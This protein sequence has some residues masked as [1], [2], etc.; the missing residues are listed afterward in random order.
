MGDLGKGDEFTRVFLFL[1]TGLCPTMLPSWERVPKY[2]GQWSPDK[3][4]SEM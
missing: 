1:S 3:S 4:R 2:L